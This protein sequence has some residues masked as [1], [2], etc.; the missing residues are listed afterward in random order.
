MSESEAEMSAGGEV[1]DGPLYPFENKFKSEKD[2]AEIMALSEVQ[3]ESILAERSL[4]IE[5]KQQNRVLLTLY[6]KL[7]SE[8]SAEANANESKK[9]K[10]GAADLQQ[11]SQR[12]STRTRKTLG[13]RKAGE[14]SDLMES[15]KRQREQKGILNEQRRREGE[16]REE[17]KRRGS[18]DDG[19]SDADADGESEVEW[20]DGKHKAEPQV[21]PGPRDELP[22]DLSDY[23]HVKIGRD[24]FAQVCFY[25]NFDNVMKNC[26]TRLSI[27]LN[28]ETGDNIYRLA[29]IKGQYGACIFA[30]IILTFRRHN[31]GK[32]VCHGRLQ[33]KDICHKSVCRTRTWQ[34]SEGMAIHRMLEWKDHRGTPRLMPPDIANS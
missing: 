25:P 12:K 11:E 5:R 3:R 18:L 28:K 1:D 30:K 7:Q 6:K 29:Q 17:R 33:R 32:A 15:Y 31:R 2:K 23:N 27:G 22:A 24:N 21:Q 26:F 13:G 20:D 9:R 19:F 16:E 14:T 10:A 34:R 8:K 4:E